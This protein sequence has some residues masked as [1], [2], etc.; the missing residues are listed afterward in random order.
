MIAGQLE[1]R[2]RKP[3]I[4]AVTL[5]VAV[6]V[7]V[8]FG[9][10]AL[11]PRTGSSQEQ[12][13]QTGKVTPRPGVPVEVAKARSTT[14]R[15]DIR[16]IGSLQ[17]DE[18]VRIAPEI[19]GR[20]ASIA[21]KEGETVKQGDVLIKLDD[22]LL[23]AEV[24]DQEARYALAKSNY[25]RANQLGRTGNITDRAR[26]EATAAFH[27]ARATLELARVRLSKHTIHAPFSGV[28][29][30]RSVSVGAYIGIGTSIVNLEKIDT[31]KVDFSIPEFHLSAVAVGN[32]V[33][34]EVDAIPNKTFT[35]EVYAIDPM[36][37]VNG[38]AVRIRARLP[39]A[40]L[41]L[42]P[43]LFARITIKDPTEQ[44]VVSVPES[45]I[46]PRQGEM[47][48]YRVTEGKAVEVKVRV[49]RRDG[50]FVEVLDGIDANT[51]VVVTGQQRL[52]NGAAVDI[53]ENENQAAG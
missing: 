41:Q 36:V 30:L 50:G 29:G 12:V 24:G 23:V 47:F 18:S 3:I 1:N 34:V 16:A 52:R 25:D 43:G 6:G 19:A 31:L 13:T 22:S 10:N 7:A 49:G 51:T 21:F 2:M 53:V 27:S 28:V 48:V 17:S 45:A 33:A 37:D 40:D 42:R 39:N 44:T 38:R 26:D 32:S 5:M 46:V 4:V 11:S 14:S 15:A 8:A 35:G 9:T 20:I